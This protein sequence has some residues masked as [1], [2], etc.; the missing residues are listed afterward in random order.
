MMSADLG[1]PSLKVAGL[2]LWVPS[3]QLPEAQGAYDG[4]WLVVTGHC[5]ASGASIWVQGAILMVTDIERFRREC[6]DLYDGKS[7]QASLDPLEP[8]LRVVLDATDRRGH[9]TAR[10]EI[11]PDHLTQTH[12]L[13]FEIDQSYLPDIIKECAGIVGTYPIRGG[14]PVRRAEA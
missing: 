5:T 8:A 1:S 7:N 4:N 12:H 6:L 9:I 10:V 11:T 14:A 3:R 13:T 2:E